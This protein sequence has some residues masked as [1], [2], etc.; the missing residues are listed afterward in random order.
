[1]IVYLQYNLTLEKKP[2]EPVGVPGC[3]NELH[4]FSPGESSLNPSFTNLKQEEN[5][6]NS[7]VKT[8]YCLC[9]PEYCMLNGMEILLIL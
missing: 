3:W 9:N 8:H 4:A 6:S 7:H 5:S 2:L 1:M